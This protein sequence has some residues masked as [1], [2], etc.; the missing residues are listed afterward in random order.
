[1]I[2]AGHFAFQLGD[3]PAAA[4]LM[5][6]AAEMGVELGERAAEGAAHLFLG[7]QQMS[8][9]RARQGTRPSHHRPRYPAG[10]RRPDRRGAKHGRTRT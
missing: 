9:R 6:K 2:A 5:T 1:M 8:R 7:L 3:V 10:D 4:G